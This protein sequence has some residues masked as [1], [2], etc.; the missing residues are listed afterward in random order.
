MAAGSRNLITDVPGLKVGNAHCETTK[1]GVTV[2]I[3]DEQA[4]ASVAILGGAPGTR[5]IA[6]LEP[7]QTVNAIDALVLSGGSAFG[8][9]AGSG[10]QV[11][12][13]ELGKGFKV[14]NA[15]IPI[16]P[17]AILFDLLNGGDKSW[18]RK[19]IYRE[20]GIQAVDNASEDFEL[21]T[22][23]A[24]FG[25][26]TADLKGGLGS[27]SLALPRGGTVGAL[28]AVNAL[29]R[30]TIGDTP[31]FWAAQSEY[32]KEF[33]GLG[34]PAQME[35]MD[36]T[37]QTKFSLGAIDASSSTNT[38]IG[39]VATDLILT[40]SEAKRVATAAHDGYARAIWPAH[41]PMDGDLLFVVSTGKRKMQD[42]AFELLELGA[43]AAQTV[44]RS[45]ARGVYS[46]K[47]YPGDTVPTYKTRHELHT[48]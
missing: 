25:A 37:V 33:G 16:T 12:L 38:T 34:W 14:G 15:V 44:S 42:P 29:G 20:M 5:D 43:Y 35:T 8:L 30:T 47:T 26:T 6:L 22:N 39:I 41:T 13:A 18:G 36:R 3:P 9:D 21:G 19:P 24:G 45:I 40:K 4:V 2:L 1:S 27:A 10:A 7:E 28:I 11:R 48:S 17:T 23:G 32:D 46:A 31:H